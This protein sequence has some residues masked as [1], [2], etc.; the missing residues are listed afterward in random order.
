MVD[1]KMS[2]ET[3]D[4][5][6]HFWRYLQRQKR[7]GLSS[8]IPETKDGTHCEAMEAKRCMEWLA[9]CKLAENKRDID[10]KT[11]ELNR[12]VAERMAILGEEN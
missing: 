3:R 9:S 5:L 2:A 7:L 1:E 8:R 4:L 11:E 10:A 6:D 12:L